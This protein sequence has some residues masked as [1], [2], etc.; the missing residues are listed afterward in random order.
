MLMRTIDES[1][2]CELDDGSLI[3]F[4]IVAIRGDRVRIGVTAPRSITVD[5]KEV[6][7]AKRRAEQNTPDV[8]PKEQ[9]NP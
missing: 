2:I 7:D 3:E 9:V 8:L 5:R 1:I 6:W 4:E